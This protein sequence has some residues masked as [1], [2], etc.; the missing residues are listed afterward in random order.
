MSL[1][2]GILKEVVQKQ[3]QRVSFSPKKMNLLKEQYP[4]IQFTVEAD[5]NRIFSDEDYQQLGIEVVSSIAD[6][7]VMFGVNP[8][9]SSA[10]IPNKKY[11]FVQDEVKSDKPLFT[12]DTML[13]LVGAYSAFRA[14]GLKFELFKLPAIATFSDQASLIT[15]LKRPVLPPLKITFIGSETNLEGAEVIMKALKI[16]KVSSAD[17]LSKNFGVFIFKR[18]T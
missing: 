5:S 10:L 13:G 4:E 7:D 17:F 18:S 8:K 3:D 12:L 1:K 2:F 11:L 14:F 9:V 6:C 15:Y 16:K